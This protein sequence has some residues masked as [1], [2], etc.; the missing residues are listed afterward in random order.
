[1]AP[2]NKG[3]RLY[4]LCLIGALC[5]AAC[6]PA[7]SQGIEPALAQQV[8]QF[9]LDATRNAAVPGLRVQVQV[10]QLDTRLRLAPC[11]TVQPYLPSG[12]RLWGAARIG[13]RCTDAAV[14]WNVFLP[15]RVDVFGPALVADAVLAAGHVLAASDL[16]LAEV[17][18]AE[19]A[20]APLARDELAVGRALARPLQAGSAVHA[21]D[22]RPRQWFAAGDSVRLV[23]GGNGW[24]IHGEGQALAPGIEGQSVRVRTETGR[25]VHGT[26]VAERLVEVAL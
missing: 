18:L 9:A 11:A 13:L 12:T 4:L 7:R 3:L 1:M 17:N 21:A 2:V 15:I 16:R 19:T 5:A 26:A 8:Q 23:A 24:R 6:G 10:G 25:I 20:N 14:R 22:L